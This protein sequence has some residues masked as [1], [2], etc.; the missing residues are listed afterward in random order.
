MKILLIYPYCLEARIHEEEI[1]VPPI[2]IYYVAALLKEN[3]YDVEILN[4]H[5]INRTPYR[6]REILAEKQPD[7]IGFSILH[8]NRWGAIEIARIA[9]Q[10]N[11]KVKV[12]LG[13][14]GA[15]FLWE[16]FLTH[17]DVV[18]FVVLG[19][20]EYTFLNLA[21][22]LEDPDGGPLESVPGLAFRKGGSL[23]RTEPAQPIDDL[24][25]LPNPARYFAYQHVVSSRGCPGK[26]TFCGSPQFWGSRVR[27]H[28]PEYFVDQLEMLYNQ[29]LTSFYFSDDTFTLKKDHVIRICSL[30]IERGLKITWVAI[31]RVNTL[32]GEVLYWMRRAGCTQISF[33]VESGSERIRN[34]I[35]NKK[36]Q[37]DQIKKAFELTTQYGI[38]PR[39]YFIYGAPGETWDTIQETLDLIRE[40]KPLSAIFYILDIFPGTALYHDFLDKKGASDDI[41]L[42]RIEDILYFEMDPY[43]NPELILAF[44]QELRSGFHK[45]L[46]AFVE[47]IQLLEKEDLFELHADFLS[48]LALTFSHGDYAGLDI[49]PG[50]EDISENLFQRS[51]AYFPDHR[52]FW[53][54]A[55][56]KQK[57]RYTDES[58]RVLLEGLKF[59]PESEQLNLCLG[60]NFMNK[61]MYD[62]ALDCFLKFPGSE[63]AAYYIVRCRE[64]LGGS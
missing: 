29:G 17:F 14:I 8:A 38:L 60:I 25:R 49:I 22:R 48:R 1:S 32:S 64:A 2:G 40:I 15:T 9:K 58:I 61:G 57:S 45:N 44:G 42:E 7:V 39:A 20:G 30:I 37:T 53:G 51:L 47:S 19:E 18:D 43:L 13:G 34:K 4:W 23:V 6:I 24:D 5:A 36:I 26:C 21:G 46:P 54:L 16:H 62:K 10:L 41:W 27:F 12:V 59:Y 11:P 63:D 55:L 50:K 35:L 28:S 33:G 3:Q 31:S 52:A 56:L